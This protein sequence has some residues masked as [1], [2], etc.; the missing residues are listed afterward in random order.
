MS[1]TNRRK[2]H[3]NNYQ[4]CSDNMFFF[5]GLLSTAHIL[6]EKYNV[7]KMEIFTLYIWTLDKKTTILMIDE[8][9]SET[10][11]CGKQVK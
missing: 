3:T 2:S 11:C 5:Q 4:D 8:V 7:L 9:L 10:Q 6:S 1:L